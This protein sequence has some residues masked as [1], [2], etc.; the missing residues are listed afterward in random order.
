LFLRK[1]LVVVWDNLGAHISAR[2]RHLVEARP[3]L[4]TYQLPTHAPELNPV[5]GLWSPIKRS[6]ANLASRTLNE[7]AALLRTR[8]K[9]MQYRPALITG[10]GTGTGLDLQPP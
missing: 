4:S 9:R 5:E 2:M 6:L 1:P 7:L 8:L 3:W 10:F